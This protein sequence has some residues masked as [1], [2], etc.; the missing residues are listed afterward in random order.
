MWLLAHG[1]TST[2]MWKEKERE[3]TLA[4]TWGTLGSPLPSPG[5]G[6][7]RSGKDWGSLSLK[8][9]P[10][11]GQWK[12]YL[13]GDCPTARWVTSSG[14][15]LHV[16]RVFAPTVA[17]LQPICCQGMGCAGCRS[18]RCPVS[19]P[20]PW[21]CR[22]AEGRSPGLLRPFAAR[23]A[24]GKSGLYPAHEQRGLQAAQ[25][26]FALAHCQCKTLPTLGKKE[27]AGWRR[28]SHAALCTV[29]AV[30]LCRPSP[31]GCRC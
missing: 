2:V 23:G 13:G 15:G 14:K 4:G 6:A 26:P 25:A 17:S 18:P 5:W 8:Q 16:L 7:V 31:W 24:S 20:S 10:G 11:A 12:R 3:E 1:K 21:F 22:G 28:H 19:L 29:A 27:R 30:M 9:L